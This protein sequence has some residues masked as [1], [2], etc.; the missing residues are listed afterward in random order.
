MASFTRV[1]FKIRVPRVRVIDENGDM[2]GVMPTREAHR[3]AQSLGLD[4]VEVSPNADPPVCKIMNYGKFRYDEGIKR[5][6]ARKNQKKTTVKEIKFHAGVEKNDLETKLKKIRMFLGQGNKVKITLQYRGR[7]NAHKELGMEV[8]KG[9]V[10]ELE[11]EASVEQ[12]PR[13][14]GRILGCLLAPKTAK[15]SSGGTKKGGGRKHE[16]NKKTP[17]D[18]NSSQE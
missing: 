15:N 3:H 18:N 10:A 17:D 1:N 4:L 16:Q 9:V 5:K 7:E 8:V 11:D 2:R 6:M 12:P 13:I 14:M